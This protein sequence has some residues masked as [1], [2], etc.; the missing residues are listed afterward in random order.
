MRHNK[1]KRTEGKY[2]QHMPLSVTVKMQTMHGQAPP[3]CICTR[4]GFSVTSELFS[5]SQQHFIHVAC[6]G[7]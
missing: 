2:E 5:V 4:T 3:P 6:V 1:K 7:I